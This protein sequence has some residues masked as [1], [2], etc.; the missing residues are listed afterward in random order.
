MYF[1]PS[2]GEIRTW[3]SFSSTIPVRSSWEPF[4]REVKR[5][6][7]E[8]ARATA[9]TDRIVW[10]RRDVTYLAA[11]KSSRLGERGDKQETI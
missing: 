5:R 9:V 10:R 4:P 6:E 8:T 7:I 3:G 11:M 2:A 1:S